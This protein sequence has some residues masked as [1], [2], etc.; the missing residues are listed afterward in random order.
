MNFFSR[1]HGTYRIGFLLSL[2]ISPTPLSYRPSHPCAYRLFRFSHLIILS[3]SQVRSPEQVHPALDL[4]FSYLLIIQI[5]FCCCI[6]SHYVNSL[7]CKQHV[8]Q[9]DIEKR[10]FYAGTAVERT[11]ELLFEDR[12]IAT[13]PQSPV[14]VA[15]F[16]VVVHGMSPR[17]AS[18]MFG[19]SL[20][21][22]LL[23]RQGRPK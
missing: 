1:L 6:F 8:I 5:L 19:A 16:R 20:G 3:L 23:R 22:V 13:S 7:L 15:G 17:R 18:R 21:A 14:A 12:R 10:F 2:Y 11:V 4:T 9:F